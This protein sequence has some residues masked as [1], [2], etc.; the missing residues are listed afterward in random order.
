MF[1]SAH[2]VLCCLFIYLF[3]L[4]L[5]FILVPNPPSTISFSN[6][7]HAPMVLFLCIV[8][9][10]VSFNVTFCFSSMSHT[11]FYTRLIL[12]SCICQLGLFTPCLCC[13]LICPLLGPSTHLRKFNSWLKHC[14]KCVCRRCR[15]WH[16]TCYVSTEIKLQAFT[17]VS[18]LTLF[19]DVCNRF[20]ISVSDLSQSRVVFLFSQCSALS[21]SSSPRRRSLHPIWILPISLLFLPRSRSS[22]PS[23]MHI[24]TIS[25][26]MAPSAV[27]LIWAFF[28]CTHPCSGCA[29][30]HIYAHKQAWAVRCLGCGEEAEWILS[31]PADSDSGWSL[32]KM[33]AGFQFNRS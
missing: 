26:H 32:Q 9:F 24:H 14:N 10:W 3:I 31:Q 6:C 2:C 16:E 7:L 15:E 17:P 29:C 20:D 21:G 18:D 22:S 1:H 28:F 13:I 19:W 5:F 30:D 23:S 33:R 25:A 27:S 4:Q 12:H 11:E 8:L